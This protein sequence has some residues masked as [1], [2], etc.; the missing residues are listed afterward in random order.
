M[1]DQPRA[2]SGQFL[3]PVTH[4]EAAPLTLPPC[5]CTRRSPSLHKST[6]ITCAI[7][8]QQ[9]PT[10]RNARDG[11]SNTHHSAHSA[12]ANTPG[13][14]YKAATKP[15]D[16]APSGR[17]IFLARTRRAQSRHY[18]DSAA[19]P[20]SWTPSSLHTIVPRALRLTLAL[21]KYTCSD[22]PRSTIAF[23]QKG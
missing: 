3:T 4:P 2:L 20:K 8:K 16:I 15:L 13:R 19:Q 1:Q 22:Y 12:G 21:Q 17:V 14:I 23:Y 18:K 5:C 9:R 11:L 10:C 6:G 7:P